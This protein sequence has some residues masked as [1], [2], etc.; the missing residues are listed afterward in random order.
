MLMQGVVK[1]PFG[2]FLPSLQLFD[3][4]VALAC[5][6]DGRARSA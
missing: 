3:P 2:G 5:V 1:S 4:P 6:G